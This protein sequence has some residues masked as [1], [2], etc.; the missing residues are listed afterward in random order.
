MPSLLQNFEMCTRT[1]PI[2]IPK[3]RQY[4]YV[5]IPYQ[6][7]ILYKD[8][9]GTRRGLWFWLWLIS[10]KA[11]VWYAGGHDIRP[12]Y[13]EKLVAETIHSYL[14]YNNNNKHKPR[15]REKDSHIFFIQTET[16]T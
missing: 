3:L 5:N 11:E 7:K 4:N 15:G 6:H 16:N 9:A 1:R 2:S 8:L 10:L 12:L 13:P 14:H